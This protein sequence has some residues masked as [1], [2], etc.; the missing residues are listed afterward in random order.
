MKDLQVDSGTGVPVSLTI[1]GPGGRAYAF[2][3]DWLC[4][5]ALAMAWYLV[6]T[7]L[8]AL[9]EPGALRLAPPTDGSTGW[10]L[11]VAVPSAAIYF[12]YHPLFEVLLRGVTPGK[13]LAGIR[14]VT[15]E[16][17]TPGVSALLI[18]NVFRLIDSFPAFY[19][20]G[21]ITTLLTSRH[22]RFGDLAAGTM[23]VYDH[24]QPASLAVPPI[25]SPELAASSL[26][27]LEAA[28]ELAERWPSL[29]PGPRAQLARSLLR[30]AGISDAGIH[31]DAS[32]LRAVC[33][34]AESTATQ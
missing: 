8:H 23:L 19:C 13:R 5:V 12:L 26:P 9:G 2:V 16:G 18:R 28:L 14:I 7:G 1:A 27:Q 21:L 4:R 22:L 15:A 34:L 20:V 33:A 11:G 17:R 32:L 6:G 29:A 25:A 24:A 10:L 30:K 31:D 3:I